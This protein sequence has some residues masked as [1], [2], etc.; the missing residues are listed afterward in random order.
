MRELT[1]YEKEKWFDNIGRF[2]PPEFLMWGAELGDAYEH[3]S[4]A[5]HMKDYGFSEEFVQAAIVET[6]NIY[7]GQLEWIYE[8]E[9]EDPEGLGLPPA[10]LLLGKAAE[11]GYTDR[12][13]LS[14]F[15]SH[16]KLWDWAMDWREEHLEDTVN[17]KRALELRKELERIEKRSA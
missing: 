12:D 10:E 5:T 14:I 6:L 3:V 7:Y 13:Y 16:R 17:Q 2:N 15:H 1:A 9:Q 11:L 8:D 4:Q